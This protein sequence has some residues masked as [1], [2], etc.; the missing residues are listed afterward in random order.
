MKKLSV[1]LCCILFFSIAKGQTKSTKIERQLSIK[2]SEH[3]LD[4]LK[5]YN[6]GENWTYKT[7]K[8]FLKRTESPYWTV[9]EQVHQ[10]DIPIDV[11]RRPGTLLRCDFSNNNLTGD[12]QDN[13]IYRWQREGSPFVNG[14]F[15]INTEYWFSFNQITTVT[16]DIVRNTTNYQSPPVI[17]FDHNLIT[18]FKTSNNMFNIQK[19]IRDFVEPLDM[20]KY[21]QAHHL[22]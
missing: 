5:K 15:N 8:E 2:I 14:L 13:P 1:V 12:L 11:Q 3:L 20:P 7:A 4:T 21:I 18:E 10:M 17:A 19:P 22:A 9:T 6:G 16:A